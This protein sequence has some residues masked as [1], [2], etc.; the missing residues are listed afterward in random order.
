MGA[1]IMH[2]MSADMNAP[3]AVLPPVFVVACTEGAA[4]STCHSTCCLQK[5]LV[6]HT[7]SLIDQDVQGLLKDACLWKFH[8]STWENKVTLGKT[9][10]ACQSKERLSSERFSF[11]MEH[12]VKILTRSTGKFEFYYLSLNHHIRFL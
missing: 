4:T 3:D 12:L 11:R 7:W 6:W 9:N 5:G 1:F 2:D 10:S 8:L